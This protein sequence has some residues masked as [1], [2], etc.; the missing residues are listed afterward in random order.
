MLTDDGLHP[1]DECG[2]IDAHQRWCTVTE[3]DAVQLLDGTLVDSEG[4]GFWR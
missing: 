1:C 3:R 2:E 4:W